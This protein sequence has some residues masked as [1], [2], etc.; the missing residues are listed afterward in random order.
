MEKR[1]VVCDTNILI[2]FYKGN[3]EIIN[4]LQGIGSQNIA[5]SSVTAAELIFGALNKKELKNIKRDLDQLFVI[6]LN[7]KISKNFI[8][9]M[10]EYTLSYNLDLPDALIASTAIIYDLELYT[11]NK[12]H[13]KYIDDLKLWE[14]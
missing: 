5:L 10:L 2:E 3:S 13:F 14:V 8:D 7:E 1:L 11:L 4:N 6:P 9:L 12:K